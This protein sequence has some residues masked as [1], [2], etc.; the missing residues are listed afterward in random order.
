MYAIADVVV[1]PAVNLLQ[2]AVNGLANANL[3]ASQGLAN[4]GVWLGPIAYMGPGW[5]ALL[6]SLLGGGALVLAL[7]AAMAA[8][9]LYL[10]LKEGVQWW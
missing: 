10:R 6:A 8:Y 1:A 5:E 9:R 3:V 4:P 7:R 2:A